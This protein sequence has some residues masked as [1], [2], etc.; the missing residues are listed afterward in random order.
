MIFAGLLRGLRGELL[1]DLEF[2]LLFERWRPLHG[3]LELLRLSGRLLLGVR[4]LCLSSTG[5]VF[6]C[7][8]D[9]LSMTFASFSAV[10][11]S[12]YNFWSRSSSARR[13]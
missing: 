10:A 13:A 12:S 5:S 6:D 11:V 1:L 8:F 4:D 9:T 2:R 3:V 7:F